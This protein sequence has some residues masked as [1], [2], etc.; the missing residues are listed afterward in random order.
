MPVQPANA[1]PAK[2]A[3]PHH[4]SG[5]DD[6]LCLVAGAFHAAD[7]EVPPEQAHQQIEDNELTF[8]H[9]FAL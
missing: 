5:D 6:G 1:G 3:E 7:A 2:Q 4:V 8:H 9:Q